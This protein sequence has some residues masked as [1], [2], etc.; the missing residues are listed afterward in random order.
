MCHELICLRTNG[1]EISDQ[2]YSPLIEFCQNT[3]NPEL[4]C[5]CTI[6]FT[7]DPLFQVSVQYSVFS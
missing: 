1:S 6:L 3:K 4:F 5:C 2:F 7:V